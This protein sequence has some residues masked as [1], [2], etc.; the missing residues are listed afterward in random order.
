MKLIAMYMDGAPC[1]C[2]LSHSSLSFLSFHVLQFFCF[3]IDLAALCQCL[4]HACIEDRDND[5][6]YDKPDSHNWHGITDW[7]RWIRWHEQ[8]HHLR[9]DHRQQHNY[10]NNRQ[11]D[12]TQD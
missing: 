8:R 2:A 3:S 9:I 10:G 5:Q 4:W 1:F 12:V 6:P 11:N 7:C